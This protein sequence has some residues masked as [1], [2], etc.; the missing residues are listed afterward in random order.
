[1]LIEIQDNYWVPAENITRVLKNDEG[2]VITI[3]DDMEVLIPF[4]EKTIDYIVE[5]I[6]LAWR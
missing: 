1:M 5:E 6:N 3:N 2:T 4:K